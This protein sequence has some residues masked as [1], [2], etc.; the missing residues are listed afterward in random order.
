MGRRLD[1]L[2]MSIKQQLFYTLIQ[3]VCNDRYQYTLQQIERNNAEHNQSANACDGRIDGSA[4]AHN[5]LQRHPEQ[6]G[7]L[8]DQIICVEHTA[9]D[10]HA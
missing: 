8:G 6:L 4:H 1:F 3:Q 5:S 10:G 2:M 7:K 9:E